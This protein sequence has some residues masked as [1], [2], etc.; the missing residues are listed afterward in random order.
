MT[1]DTMRWHEAVNVHYDTDYRRLS[2]ADLARRHVV[3]PDVLDM[4]CITGSLMIPLAERGMHVVGLD[5]YDGAVAITN[6]RL[7][8]KRLA[9]T[10]QLWELRDLVNIVGRDRFDTVACLDVLNHVESDDAC[11][12]EIV[13]VVKP[14]GRVIFAVP[15]FPALL[16]KRDKALGH[17]RRY[18]RAGIRALL[19]QHGLVVDRHRFWNF[20][21]LPLYAFLEAGLKV[22]LSDKFRFGALGGLKQVP[23]RFLTAWYRT[24][25]NNVP[26]PL[27]LTHFVI[28]HRPGG[29]A[30]L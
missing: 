18:T 4:R 19:E 1:I 11:M 22:R 29:A 6:E 17:L 8:Q 16:G 15:A 3:G 20:A 27:G 24:V 30:R 14:G 9:P 2:L 7:E 12:A 25:E 26:F 13:Q 10:A 23:Y 5:G 21:A 28:A